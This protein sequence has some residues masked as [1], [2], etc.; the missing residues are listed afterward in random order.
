MDVPGLAVCAGTLQQ[1][2]KG[3]V[4]CLD[5]DV[6]ASSPCGYPDTSLPGSPG[7]RTGTGPFGAEAS[8]PG[9]SACADA[10]RS[11]R[12]WRPGTRPLRVAQNSSPGGPPQPKS[13]G[14]A[15]DSCGRVV[16]SVGD[17]SG[18]PLRNKAVAALRGVGAML[19]A[20]TAHQARNWTLFRPGG[21]ARRPDTRCRFGLWHRTRQLDRRHQVCPSGKIRGRH[22]V[23]RRGSPCIVS[24]GTP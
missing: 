1:D 18:T 12:N 8:R 11:S 24:R 17:S 20:E 16:A 13:A 15:S 3:G 19:L 10:G 21:R 7:G 14:S 6:Q 23:R 22:Q 5:A 2:D 9:G 4:R